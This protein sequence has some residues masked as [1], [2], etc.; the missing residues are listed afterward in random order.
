VTLWRE[1][2]EQRETEQ[3]FHCPEASELSPLLA[4]N[5]GVPDRNMDAEHRPALVGL[6]APPFFSASWEPFNSRLFSSSP[7]LRESWST[8]SNARRSSFL[9]RPLFF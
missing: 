6:L 8:V 4:G 9:P 2:F 7:S 3:P 1:N 5:V